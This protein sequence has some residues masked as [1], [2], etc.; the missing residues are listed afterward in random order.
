[1]R[2]RSAL[3][4]VPALML[5]AA[6]CGKDTKKSDSAASSSSSPSET[7]S[8]SASATPSAT[9]STKIVSG[10]VPA[11]TSGTAFN[12]KPTVAKG[13]G[14][15]STDLAVKTLI[16][17]KGAGVASGDIVQVNYLGQVW[18]TAKVF[19]TNFGKTPYAFQT[20]SQ[21]V[22]PG[23]EQAVAGAKPNSRVITAIPPALG[24][25]TSGNAQA[26]IKGTDTLV[27]VIDVLNVYTGKDS[28]KGT[29]VPQTDANLPKVGTNTDGK[30][31][32]VTVPKT[33][34]PTKLVSNYVLEGDGKAV[35]AS[36]TLV[37]QYKGVLWDG[38]KEFDS[39]YSRNQVTQFPLSSVIPGWT[40]G[41]TGKKVGSRVMLVTPPAL[42]YKDQANGPVPA[43][44]TLVF[45][46]DII[47]VL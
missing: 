35:K 8:A 46:V 15:P 3:L 16:A 22:I 14:T 25:G 1:M 13:T 36:D 7:P 27:F 28:A 12:S 33:K 21:A 42:A 6:G 5:T 31:P 39:S 43:N 45:S 38:G 11:V 26:G 20:G 47:A 24:Y 37:V 30:A 23:F 17:G 2:R 32:S 10:P 9:P 44:A 40:Q 18:S 41:L 19:D 29:V 34:A 4:A